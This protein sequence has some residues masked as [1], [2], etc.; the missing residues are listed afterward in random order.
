[1]IKRLWKKRKR[2]ALAILITLLLIYMLNKTY[3]FDSVPFLPPVEI[4]QEIFIRYNDFG[5]G[6]FGASR[7]GGRTHMGLDIIAE[8]GTP[9][10]AA[11]S[12][13]VTIGEVPGGMGKFVRITHPGDLI[14]VY[15]HLSKVNVRDGQKVRQGQVIGGVGK[16]GNANHPSIKSHLHFEI[17]KDGKPVDPIKYLSRSKSEPLQ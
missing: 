14:T 16:T 10:M 5:S 11:K 17:R 15:G 8:V 4:G 3:Y 1:M 9:V 2:L 6:E 12:G 7:K 13:R